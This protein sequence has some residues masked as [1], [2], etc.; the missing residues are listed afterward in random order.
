MVS[1]DKTALSWIFAGDAS[2]GLKSGKA[3]MNSAVE[4]GMGAA[5]IWD[6]VAYKLRSSCK[7]HDS[8]VVSKVPACPAGLEV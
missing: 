3:G 2:G 8:C 5:W 6:V 7:T 4:L 1:A